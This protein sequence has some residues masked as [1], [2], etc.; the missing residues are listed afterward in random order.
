MN[1]FSPTA[2]QQQFGA[3]HGDLVVQSIRT[4]QADTDRAGTA[5]EGTLQVY[6]QRLRHAQRLQP[7]RSDLVA[8]CQK[9]VSGLEATSE[10]ENLFSW[11][12]VLGGEHLTGISTATRIVVSMPFHPP[13]PTVAQPDTALVAVAELDSSG[14]M[15]AVNPD[16]S[17]PI[18]W[19]GDLDDDC[20][21]IWS[22]LMLRAEWMDGSD[23]WWAVSRLD[24]G[25]QIRSS[26]DDARP[27]TSGREAR[28]LA[29]EAAR[30]YFSS[31]R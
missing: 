16:A 11:H 4:M 18:V 19:T 2:L 3:E 10:Q 24:A 29:E 25:G 1:S 22:G 31:R 26:H 28:L 7:P 12:V 23:W 20:T 14:Q 21:A 17:S 15:D 30:A 27:C 13:L 6:R 9:V 8:L 5:R